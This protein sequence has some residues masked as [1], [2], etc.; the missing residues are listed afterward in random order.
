MTFTDTVTA[1]NLNDLVEFD[2]DARLVRKK[3]FQS[4]IIVSELVCY[5][6]GQ[7]TKTHVHPNQDEIFFCMQGRGV[8]TFSDRDDIAI[9]PGSLVFVPSGVEHGVDTVGDERLVLMFTKGPGIP[10]PRKPK[11]P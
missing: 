4:E 7:L 3:M 9:E 6:P 5:E 2:K 10:N 11:T 8:I 1:V